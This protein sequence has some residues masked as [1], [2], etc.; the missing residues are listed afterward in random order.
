MNEW[1]DIFERAYKLLDHEA[2]DKASKNPAAIYFAPYAAQKHSPYFMGLYV[3]GREFLKPTDL[4]S[5]Q[6]IVPVKAKTYVSIH[7]SDKDRILKALRTIDPS[8][9]YDKWIR[10]G[11]ALHYE[12]GDHGF[13]IW[14][15]WS[16]GGENYPRQGQKTLAQHWKSFKKIS[17]PITIGTLFQIAK[18]VG[19]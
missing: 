5:L 14:D 9:P 19:S 16:M 1:D 11:M 17:V 4:P 3:E 6:K 15:H 2:A 13:M 8:L 7:D 10:I 18:G 12:W